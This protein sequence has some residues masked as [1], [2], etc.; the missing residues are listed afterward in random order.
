MAVSFSA[1]DFLIRHVFLSLVL[2]LAYSG[3]LYAAIESYDFQNDEQRERYLQLSEELRCPK[4]QN[5]NLADS[6]SQIA[7]DLRRELHQQLLD[8]KSDEAIVDFM[9]DRYGDFV[10]Y[11]P[12]VQRNTLLLWWGP[13]GLVFIVA[14]L[15][16]RSR[17]SAAVAEKLVNE[18]V[19]THHA[20]SLQDKKPVAARWV[21]LLSLLVL[22]AVAIGSLAL[23]RYL[24]SLQAIEITELGQA[25]FSRQ[26]P[27]EEQVKQ[28]EILL[29]ELD[30]WL[31]NHPE[32]DRFIYMRARLL[33][34]AGVW[35]RA[36]SDY[37]YLVSR[38]PEQDNMLAEYAQ[39]LFLQNQRV[40]TPD[41]LAFLKQTLQVN[42]HNITALG[43]LGMAAF[44]QK[45]YRGAV[46]FWQR[47]LRV[48]P[49]GTPQA[50]TI[51]EGV[52]RAKDMGGLSDAS[53]VVPDIRL[54]VQVKMV[55]AAQATPDETVFVL[56]R[57]V[58]G[59]RM[60]L[61][62]VKT[63]VAALVQPIVL[64]TATSPMRGQLDLTAIESFEVVARLS[65]SGQP[66]SA[67]GD[68]EGISQPFARASV[69]QM[70]SLSVEKAISP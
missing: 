1:V 63:T 21:N 3:N 25:V 60:P 4:C 68:W 11:K 65:R 8:G 36:V 52:A 40:M 19:V 47:L 35:D 27:A 66:I 20:S 43:L 13:I 64:D 38:F 31:G 6:D 37:R 56:L 61:A 15:L 67:A 23:Y 69:P 58:N 29:A 59:P 32:D 53:V 48:I 22:L 2:F 17:R 5:Q 18:S 54:S 50:E 57:A 49:A 51:A 28:Q 45:D 42:P 14:V 62:A 41:V 9:R 33:S 7:A 30:D 24:G 16:W 39:V 12:R 44:E 70:L 55:A 34:E 46:D 26:L 10:L